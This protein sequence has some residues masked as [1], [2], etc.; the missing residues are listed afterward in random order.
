M[1]DVALCRLTK[2]SCPLRPR[3]RTRGGVK[4]ADTPRGKRD[5]TPARHAS[6]RGLP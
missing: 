5:I 1:L 6:F 2:A 4:L 3:T